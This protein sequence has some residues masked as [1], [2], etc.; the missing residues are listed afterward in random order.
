ND[1]S[2]SLRFFNDR[3]QFTGGITDLRQQQ[4]NEWNVFRREGIA[5]DA[6]LLYLIHKDGRLVLRGSNKLNTRR[7]LLTHTDA[8]ISALGLIYRKEFKSLEEF[9][10]AKNR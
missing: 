4:L 2:A 5:T 1:A 7:F 6:E 3:L 10:R 9:F 8:Y